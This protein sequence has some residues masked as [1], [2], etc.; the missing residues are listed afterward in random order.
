V[1][2]NSQGRLTHAA[3]AQHHQL[4]QRHLPRHLVGV[5]ASAMQRWSG[6]S[7]WMR[8]GN[9]SQLNKE[10]ISGAGEMRMWLRRASSE[11]RRRRSCL[12]QARSQLTSDLSLRCEQGG[13]PGEGGAAVK[14]DG[15]CGL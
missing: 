12:V 5:V 10:T 8:P 4:I 1:Y 9:P 15:V 13:F 3:V 6:W 14:R 7:K 2:L 11:P